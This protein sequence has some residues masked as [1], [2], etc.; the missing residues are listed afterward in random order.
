MLIII[1]RI[2]ILFSCIYPR[3]ADYNTKNKYPIY[4]YI[5][6]NA[7]YN[8]KN[9]NSSLLYIPEIVDYNTKNKYSSGLNIPEVLDYNTTL[10]DVLTCIHERSI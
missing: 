9:N 10:C 5:P 8:T 1:Q 3:N 7:D 4:L 2:T 6:Q